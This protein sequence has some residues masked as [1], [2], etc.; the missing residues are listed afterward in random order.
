MPPLVCLPPLL[1]GAICTYRLPM[2]TIHA[3]RQRFFF[4]YNCA[5]PENEA[6][7]PR[8]LRCVRQVLMSLPAATE[9]SLLPPPVGRPACRGLTRSG[10]HKIL[11]L[12][13]LLSL[14]RFSVS[15]SLHTYITTHVPALT[16]P[17]S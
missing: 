1:P 7:P 10:H 12:L 17:A 13:C 14:P 2:Y 11:C 15:L 9:N 16:L 6:A 4:F 5:R 8:G 3:A